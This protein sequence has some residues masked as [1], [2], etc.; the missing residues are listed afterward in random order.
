MLTGLFI[1]AEDD[2]YE[3]SL[4]SISLKQYSKRD[5]SG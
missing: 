5:N 2:R 3:G 1:Y 4:V